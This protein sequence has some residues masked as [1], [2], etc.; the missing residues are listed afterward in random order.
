[1]SRFRIGMVLGLGVGYVL[2]ARAG[3]ERYEQ[4]ARTAKGAWNSQTAQW[5]RTEVS[6][7]MPSAVTS[8]VEK[9]VDLRH[10][11]AAQEEMSRMPA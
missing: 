9:V 5:M 4:I 10:R 3:R 2:G 1:M 6:Q 7:G 11:N 8:A